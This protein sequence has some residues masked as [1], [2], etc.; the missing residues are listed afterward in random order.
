MFR[1]ALLTSTAAALLL[2]ACAMPQ[3]G[4]P[5][6]GVAHDSQTMTADETAMTGAEAMPGEMT[7]TNETTTPDE[8]MHDDDAP[9]DDSMAEGEMPGDAAMMTRMALPAWAATPLVDARSGASF[10][11][12]D[13]AGKTIFVE[14]MATWCTNCRA[15]LNNIKT[16]AEQL[17]GAD[18]VFVALSVETNLDAA[19]LASY[20]EENG[21]AWTFAIA[22]PELLLQLA[23][24]FGQTIANPPATPHFIVSPDGAVSELYT[25]IESPAAIV[26]R[27]QE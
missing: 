26:A 3:P 15:Q 24:D 6:A 4:A 20:A 14:P 7:A 2:A 23:G 21:F 5:D 18:V 8:R 16:A 22:T 12:N 9:L 10:T 11:L 27:V 13:F 1:K 17:A 19:A 25:G